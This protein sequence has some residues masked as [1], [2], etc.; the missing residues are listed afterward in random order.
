MGVFPK[1]HMDGQGAHEEMFNN[2]NYW[3][4]AD[5]N[6]SEVSRH[7]GQNGHHQKIYKEIMLERVWRGF[8]LQCW[9][10]HGLI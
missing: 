7:N 3:R 1:R 2:T 9:W 10:E 4:R 5:Q 6:Y 8:L